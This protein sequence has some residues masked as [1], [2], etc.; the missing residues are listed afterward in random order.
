MVQLQQRFQDP[1]ECGF[2]KGMQCTG[3]RC[4]L[5]D[6]QSLVVEINACVIPELGPDLDGFFLVS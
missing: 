2:R 6:M 1:L 4:C 3:L 5:D